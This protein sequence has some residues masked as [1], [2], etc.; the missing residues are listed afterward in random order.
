MLLDH[1]EKL[2][3]C[4]MFHRFATEFQHCVR[5]W[6]EYRLAFSLNLVLAKNT[7]FTLISISILRILLKPWY[8][9]C[10]MRTSP[11]LVVHSLLRNWRQHI[12][13]DSANRLAQPLLTN[14]D[15]SENR[16]I[17][18]VW[19][20]W[21][22][23]GYLRLS[24]FFVGREGSVL[25]D[26]MR[27]PLFV[28]ATAAPQSIGIFSDRN[29]FPCYKTRLDSTT[30]ARQ[31]YQLHS[32]QVIFSANCSLRKWTISCRNRCAKTKEYLFAQLKTN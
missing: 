27:S 14:T 17:R 29:A 18:V 16:V 4:E 23:K 8:L 1:F 5:C 28:W 26:L 9:E 11:A 7:W 30:S 31:L 3:S 6:S 20:S 13:D 15:Q 19:I 22:D 24:N 25:Y 12:N 21:G 10:S 32:L 2:P